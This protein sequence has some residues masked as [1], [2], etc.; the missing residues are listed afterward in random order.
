MEVLYGEQTKKC[1]ETMSFSG[2]TLGDY[3]EYVR[4]MLRVKMAAARANV[5]AGVLPSQ[6]T[7][8]IV[9]ACEQAIASFDKAQYPVDVYH[10]GGGIGI[11]MNINEVIHTLASKRSAV[12]AI[13]HINRSQ[14]TA[15]VCHTAIRITICEL[16][17]ELLVKLH[18]CSSVLRTKQV[19]FSGI[20]TIARTC[21]MDAMAMDLGHR[22]SGYVDVVERRAQAIADHQKSMFTVNLGG[23]VIGSG[24]GAAPGYRNLVLA[25]L[26]SICGEMFVS[27]RNFFDAAQNVDELV[28]LS[29]SLSNLAQVFVKISQDLRFLSSGPEAG[30][31]EL[32]LPKTQSGSS[33]FPGK[34]N[35]VL[36]EMMMQCG[37]LVTGLTRTIEA[38]QLHGDTDL[39]VFEEFAG[40]LVMDEIRMVE[41]AL[42]L[43]TEFALKG[44][45]VNREQCEAHANSL[46]P[47][48]TRMAN[49]HGYDAVSNVIQQASEK[50]ISLKQALVESFPALQTLQQITSNTTT[51]SE[52]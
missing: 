4:N 22:F 51:A 29:Q 28:A 5:K 24:E 11:N 39:N 3:P 27:P 46:V 36:P 19:E 49:E 1:V 44:L 23:T 20:Q 26:R 18:D 38:A 7:D 35:P 6:F 40:V 17:D 48:V 25:E 13:G 10:G 15:D 21:M 33:F 12:D 41:K 16:L 45:S 37:F 47:M 32:R 9:T 50:G 8:N 52:G 2:K 34:V 42:G 30:I 14:S 31:G 43:F